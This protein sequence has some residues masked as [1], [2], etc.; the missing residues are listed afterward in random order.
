MI[1]ETASAPETEPAV[2]PGRLHSYRLIV[3]NRALRWL[4]LGQSTS[5]IGDSFFELAVSWVVYTV[6][7]SALQS[8]VIQVVWHLSDIIFGPFSGVAADRW[9]RRTLMIVTNLLAF[10]ITGLVALLMFTYGSVPPVVLFLAVFL[11]NSTM[12]FFATAHFAVLPSVVEPK[13]LATASGVFSTVQQLIGLVSGPLAG[14]CIAL[15]GSAWAVAFDACSF[16]V[17]AVCVVAARLPRQT[18][19]P[20]PAGIADQF[21]VV[22]SIADGWRAIADQPVL[23]ALVWLSLLLNV[24]SFTGPLWPALVKQQLGGGAFELGLLSTSAVIGGIVGGAAAGALE[25]HFG[26]GWLV[27]G[28]WVAVGLCRLGVALSTSFAVT[29]GLMLVSFAGQVIANVAFGALKQA[30]SPEAYRGRVR[31]ISAGL[32]V[33]AIPPSAL[34]GGW[35]TDMV[36]VA[37][38]FAAAGF[39]MLLIATLAALSHHIRTV[40]IGE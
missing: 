12:I 29:A 31:G 4:W 30:L 39:W 1:S 25:R 15:L 14:I 38:M 11:L 26:A 36:G 35:L 24:A 9:D 2:K 40:R 18:P 19:A 28:G 22:R 16:L 33:L 34:L 6:S 21:S 7:N 10:A 8:A 17:A 37:P 13:L 32:A 20:E 3:C 23:K 5:D 27:I